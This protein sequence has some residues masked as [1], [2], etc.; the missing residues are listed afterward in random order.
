MQVCEGLW[1]TEKISLC[2]KK[3]EELTSKVKFISSKALDI[4]DTFQF[5]I[6]LI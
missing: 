6:Y 2:T 1:K 4:P 3:W 5:L